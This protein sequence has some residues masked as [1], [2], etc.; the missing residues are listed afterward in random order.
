MKAGADQSQQRRHG[1]IGVAWV[2]EMGL[3]WW[4]VTAWAATTSSHLAFWR[5]HSRPGQRQSLS[6]FLA[7]HSLYL[8]SCLLA[9]R[10]FFFFFFSFVFRF[11]FG[12]YTLRT[13]GAG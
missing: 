13:A 6:Q 11:P 1:E 12:D 10:F 4:R 5:L 3:A 7:S 8:A 9:L 2:R